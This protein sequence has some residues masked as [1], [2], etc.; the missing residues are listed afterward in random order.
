[1]FQS[2]HLIGII[3]LE[4]FPSRISQVSPVLIRKAVFSDVCAAQ[5]GQVMVIHLSSSI[6][7]PAHSV[8]CQ[9]AL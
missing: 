1:M 3:A 4:A 5:G 8:L 6:W 7:V 9:R 2:H